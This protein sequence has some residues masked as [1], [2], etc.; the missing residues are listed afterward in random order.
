MFESSFASRCVHG[1]QT[2]NDT[3][4]TRRRQA[5]EPVSA[6]ISKMCFWCHSHKPD[7]F[8]NTG[9]NV[10][11]DQLGVRLISCWDVMWTNT[12]NRHLTRSWIFA[13]DALY[14]VLVTLTFARCFWFPRDISPATDCFPCWRG[15]NKSWTQ[16]VNIL[17][18]CVRAAQTCA[19]RT[20]EITPYLLLR[21]SR[22]SR[23][24]I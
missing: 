13:S 14:E 2:V 20:L 11:R 5:T 8:T 17:L 22:R 12:R 16:L 18:F 9:P 3:S 1:F 19:K 4:D 7:V 15:E 21:D 10:A 24:G 23:A 6:M